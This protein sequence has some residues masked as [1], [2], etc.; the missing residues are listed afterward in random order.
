MRMEELTSFNDSL[1][2]IEKCHTRLLSNDHNFCIDEI[3]QMLPVT[4]VV[5]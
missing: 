1:H 3:S 4:F 5:C 2:I